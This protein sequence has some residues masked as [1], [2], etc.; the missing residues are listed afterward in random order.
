VK[1]II[2][3]DDDGESEAP[4]SDLEME[5]RDVIQVDERWVITALP[6]MPHRKI[7]QF[8]I[9]LSLFHNEDLAFYLEKLVQGLMSLSPQETPTT[10]A[11]LREMAALCVSSE[12]DAHVHSYLHM[13][14]LLQFALWTERYDSQV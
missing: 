8:I 5:S 10:P 14:S 13:R 6:C 2:S 4:L 12:K 1:I 7:R 11:N 3:H 9:K